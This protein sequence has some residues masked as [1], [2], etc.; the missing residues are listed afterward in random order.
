M[1]HIILSF[2][3]CVGDLRLDVVGLAEILLFRAIFE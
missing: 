3:R 2:H 1:E